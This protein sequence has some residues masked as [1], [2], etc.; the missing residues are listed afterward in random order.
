VTPIIS[1]GHSLGSSDEHWTGS[2]LFA[3]WGFG[4]DPDW[5]LF[6]IL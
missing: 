5:E 6:Q 1:A 2:G 4:L 3:F